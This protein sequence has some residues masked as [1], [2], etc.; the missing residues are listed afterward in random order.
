MSVTVGVREFREELA[1]F[2]DRAE[3]VT[4]TRHGEA[5]G[6]FIPVKPDRRAI[7][8]AAVEASKK[9]HAFLE[10]LG[11]TEDEAVAEIEAARKSRR[12]E[13]LAA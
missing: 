1:G 4:V 2:I 3:P 11:L 7:L 13:E 8:D 10:E 12:V 6:L 5:V 9:A